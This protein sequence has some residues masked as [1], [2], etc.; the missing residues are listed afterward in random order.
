ML[1]M[2]QS[3][4]VSFLVQYAADFLAKISKCVRSQLR[5]WN[6]FQKI[7]F[8]NLLRWAFK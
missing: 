2:V 3:K 4:S 6:A 7:S 5:L 1:I 8:R